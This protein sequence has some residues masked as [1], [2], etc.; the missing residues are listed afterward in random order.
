M[1]TQLR[2]ALRNVRK[3]PV[4][5]L[6]NVGGLAVGIAAAFVLS[7]Y[8]R[9]ELSYDRHF[10][11][12]DRIYRV[13]TDFFNMG[14][15]A[16]S[17]QQLLDHL[18]QA[19]GE[20]ELVSR[21]DR[22]F[23]PT[24][25]H[26]D[27]TIYE[28]S[29]YFFVDSTFFRMFSHRFLEGQAGA[30]MRAPDEA[31][32]SDRLAEKYFGSP[33]AGMGRTLLVG[34]EKRAYRVT[35]VVRTRGFNTHLEAD[36]WL[37]LE[38]AE[39]ETYW[40]NV[41][42]YNYVKLRPGGTRAELERAL[43]LLL[44]DYAY[45]ASQAAESFESWLAGPQAVRFWVQPLTDI[46][47]H[48]DFRFEIG[49]GGNPTQVYVLALIG[50]FILLIAGMNYVTLTT[51]RS[52]VRA[53]EIGVKKTLGA[54]K[55]SL[56]RGFLTETVIVSLLAAL[57]AAGLAEV[58]LAVFA[59]ITG[60]PLEESIVS[61][62]W[63]LLALALF[64]TGVGLLAGIYPA[65]YLSSFRPVKILKGEWTVK[66]NRRLRATLVVIQFAMATGLAIGSLVIYQQLAFM[67]KAD[68]GF[69]DDGVLVIE[70]A[71]ML[72]TRS[73][74]FRQQLA[75]QPQVLSSSV[76]M[77]TPTASGIS[78]RTYQTP[79]MEE[80]ITIQ[81]FS[82]DEHY[83][84][85]LGMRLVAGRNFSAELASDTSAAILNQSAGR[86]LGLGEDP[87]GQ[88]INEGQRV[89]G[90]ISDFHFQSLRHRIEPV[91]LTYAPTGR[92][93]IL[94]LHR[95]DAGDLVAR[96]PLLWRQ[97][98]SDESIRYAFLDDNFLRLAEQE[99]MLSKAASFFTLL[100]VVIACVGLFG[101]TTFA[102]ERRTK[103]MGIR[104]VFGASVPGLVALLWQ[105]TLR[106]VFL[107]CV[108]VSPIVYF[109]MNDWLENYAYRIDLNVAPFLIG[110]IAALGIA[111]LT[112]SYHALRS[113]TANP[114]R[115]LRHE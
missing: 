63:D 96:L 65:F 31:V 93:L 6:L 25:V 19:Y 66:G 47:L 108:V 26:V 74:A 45:P 51:A 111:L 3:H 46:H 95:E 29:R 91:V 115:S 55:G 67:Q 57:V 64:S 62:M 5:A 39:P 81:T 110:S 32:L 11:G 9:Q 8:V 18:S 77:R 2:I 106:L 104:K 4:Y 16:K 97:F 101:L 17:Q 53:K 52:S 61:G 112:V 102:M 22:G 80:S 33:A 75:Q 68:K 13:A 14:G 30:V 60:T 100:A 35:G 44:R 103:E 48:S 76:A 78:V 83:I 86:A 89:I 23:Q 40:T 7:L 36:L 50:F 24:P 15:F 37:P 12:S 71:G 90:V 59:S 70:N 43:N 113:A 20:I 105:D 94:K 41:H 99:R 73:D 92:Q 98:T 34:S 85:T 21:F 109:L 84:P 69:D 28:E 82:G 114:I 27:G 58:L 1:I 38:L 56:I 10:E 72:G 87:I 54:G 88:E 49:A 107:A 42:Y 79:T